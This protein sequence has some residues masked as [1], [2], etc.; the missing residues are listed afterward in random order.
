[1]PFSFFIN[2]CFF[3]A[4]AGVEVTAPVLPV[5]VEAIAISAA[6]ASHLDE[7]ADV[8]ALSF[9]PRE[10]AQAWVWPILR[11]TIYEDVKLRLKANKP[12]YCCLGAWA[13][14]RLVG[15][16]EVGMRR[17]SGGLSGDRDRYPYLANLAVL[18][19]WRRQGIAARLLSGAEALAL[20]WGSDRLFL[21]V[22]ESNGVARRLY[23]RS[24][25]QLRGRQGGWWPLGAARQLLLTKAL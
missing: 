4:R 8:L 20:T 17:T 14:G 7:I 2:N 21:H 11:W 3:T 16:L 23:E 25:F 15:V 19:G 18:P 1:M 24:G 22:L 6:A 9:H 10:G 13:D 5:D 12:D